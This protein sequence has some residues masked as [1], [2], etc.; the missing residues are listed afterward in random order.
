MGFMD[1]MKAASQSAVN[2]VAP[3]QTTQPA[4]GYGPPP[5]YGAPTAAP[6]AA[7]PALEYDEDGELES[8][9]DTNALAHGPWTVEEF[10]SALVDLVRKERP[11]GVGDP[12]TIAMFRAEQYKYWKE[13]GGWEVRQNAQTRL[14]AASQAAS[15]ADQTN[16]LLQPVQGVTLSDYTQINLKMAEAADLNAVLGAMGIDPVVWAEASQGWVDRMSSDLTFVVSTEFG[17]LY[18][19]GITDS[20]LTGIGGAIVTTN[21]ANLER[22]RTDRTFV[23]ELSGGRSAAYNAGLDGNSWMMESFGVSP[24]DFQQAENGWAQ[25]HQQLSE[26]YAAGDMTAYQQLNAENITDEGV[27]QWTDLSKRAAAG[28]A[29]ARQYV[30]DHLRSEPVNASVYYWDLVRE[31]FQDAYAQKF[32]AQMGGGAADDI[33]F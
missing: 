16:P 25:A 24:T 29:A 28:D 15:G 30:R 20:R 11:E 1:K 27:K 32:T 5:G 13:D 21:P 18:Q 7:R 19:L 14:Q 22:L 2:A 8:C 6:Q 3:G 4:T 33:S 31:A 12:E 23:Q 17:R 10:E 9:W 26:R